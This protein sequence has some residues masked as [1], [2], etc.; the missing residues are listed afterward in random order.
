MT[1]QQNNYYYPINN[2]IS[3]KNTE[4]GGRN[5]P[6]ELR[7]AAYV[8]NFFFSQLQEGKFS[9]TN[10]LLLLTLSTSHMVKFVY[11]N[12]ILY[13]NT[14][15]PTDHFLW[16]TLGFHGW[17]YTEM[18]SCSYFLPCEPVSTTGLSAL[19]AWNTF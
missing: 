5:Q 11:R 19:I 12:A 2:I 7:G 4:L 16:S 13:V 1:Y 17:Y 9:H 10:I 3:I 14:G 18:P 8:A 15:N 6:Q